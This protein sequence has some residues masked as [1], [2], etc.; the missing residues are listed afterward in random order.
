MSLHL[1]GVSCAFSLGLS[2]LVALSYSDLFIFVLFYCSSDAHLFYYEAER[3]WLPVGGEVGR[4]R[5]EHREG[6]A[7]IILYC[8]E[9]KINFQEKKT[10]INKKK[11]D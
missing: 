4:N 9:K 8:K 1:Y 10:V 6:E 2:C 5:E 11:F 7:I 3:V